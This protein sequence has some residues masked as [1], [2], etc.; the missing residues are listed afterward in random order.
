MVLTIAFAG[1]GGESWQDPPPPAAQEIP[2][3]AEV[4]AWRNIIP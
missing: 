1:W 2:A 4:V 3:S